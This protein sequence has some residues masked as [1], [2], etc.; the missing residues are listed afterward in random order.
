LSEISLIVEQYIVPS[1]RYFAVAD[2]VE[3]SLSRAILEASGSPMPTP[4]D[5]SADLHELAELAATG[6][7]EDVLDRAL[8]ALGTIIPYDLAAVFRLDGQRARVIAGAGRLMG[9]RIRA[10]Q[11]DLAKF[12]TIR[13]VL[14]S[15]R[16]FALE[17]HHHAGAEG[18]PY[19]GVLDLPHGH[20]C[21]VVPLFAGD[22]TLGLITLD[23]RAC[24]TYPAQV[25]EMAGVYGHLVSLALVVAEQAALLDRYR[26]QLKEENRLLVE[27]T[28]APGEAVAN[29]EAS[30][31]TAT[32]DVLRLVRQAAPSDAPVLVLGETGTG[33][34]GVAQAIHAM[35]PRVDGPFVTL[36]CSAIPE[37]LVESELFGHV[38]G[39]FSG[40]DRARP[41]RFLTAN[42]GTLL[43]DEI[44]DMP[45]AA[46]A[47]LLRVLQ[48]GTFE[49]VGSD[50]TVKVDVR[51]VAATHVDLVRAV[52]DGRFRSDLYYRLA[53][54][55][56]PLPPLRDRRDDV[57]IIATTFLARTA[58]RTGRGPW[59]LAPD[60]LALLRAAPW[61]G[62]VRELVNVLER[63]TILV[64]TGVLSARTLGLG[65]TQLAAPPAPVANGALVAPQGDEHALGTWQDNERRYFED[66][67]VRT[68]GRLYGVGGAAAIAGLKPTTLRSRMVKLGMR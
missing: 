17:E 39:A 7:P 56:I 59:T 23:R 34:E 31:S 66:L 11:L 28:G 32:R 53:V 57:E 14:E 38:K 35:S 46:Q 12:P 13:H 68:G 43:L 19:D 29:L 41:G 25:V 64:P 58:R 10:H 15:R 36:N 2:G 6:T 63:A 33:K 50:R 21:M 49:A 9:P 8:H 22:R 44:G 1:R 51:I 45:L 37:N 55:P 47:R 65:P 26:H 18:D 40:A 52:A 16:P 42:G 48:E 67:L 27:Q 60:A 61:P 5:Y 30:A 62:N 24:A 3:I 20:A 54:F 4:L